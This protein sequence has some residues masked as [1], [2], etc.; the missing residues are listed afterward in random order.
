MTYAQSNIELSR[1]ETLEW[2]LCFDQVKKPDYDM[3]QAAFGEMS[4][5]RSRAK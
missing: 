1:N 5:F 2:S 4:E 3:K